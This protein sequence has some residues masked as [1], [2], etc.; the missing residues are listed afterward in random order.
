MRWH[1][2]AGRLATGLITLT[3]IAGCAAGTGE[4]T[5]GV[6]G[7]P[8]PDPTAPG[9][10]APDPTAPGPT[11]APRPEPTD[12]AT[13][14]GAPRP[15]GVAGLVVRL[16]W[17]SDAMVPI[18]G[19]TV[20]DDGRVIWAVADGV[21][22][23]QLTEAGLAWV[24]AQL[25]ATGALGSNRIV[26]AT[27]K[28]GA[29]PAPRGVTVYAFQVERD[30]ARIKVAAGDPGDYAHEPELW[31]IPP[32]MPILAELAR[33]LQ[34]PQLWIDPALW[35][36]PAKPYQAQ[37]YLVIIDLATGPPA[38]GPLVDDIDTIAWPFTV[39]I[40][41]VGGPYVQG[42][43]LVENQR[44]LVATAEVARS[45]ADAEAAAGRSR[46]LDGWMFGLIY[47]WERG[48]G[49]IGVISQPMLPYQSPDCSGALAW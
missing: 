10:T 24:R 49:Y 40:E 32:E 16:T 39:P 5:P 38:F 19:T 27:L 48:D 46:A 45:M 2:I 31:V 44:C 3:L 1:E 22:E 12:I 25:D 36:G 28:P 15:P 26:G 47:P 17:V 21:V 20:L 7:S 43:R 41:K 4:T 34:D 29:Q 42:G 33:G 11:E 30:G 18:P 9:P 23:R 13:P 35:A 14:T 37:A 6:T 8:P